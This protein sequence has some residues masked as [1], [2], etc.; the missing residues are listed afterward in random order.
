MNIIS[1]QGSQSM[2]PSNGPATH[3]MQPTA[4]NSPPIDHRGD[5]HIAGLSA[6]KHNRGNDSMSQLSPAK[7]AERRYSE[8][9]TVYKTL[10]M[11]I[12]KAT[13]KLFE[14]PQIRDACRGYI[15][16][17]CFLFRY[18]NRYRGR[19]DSSAQITDGTV[20]TMTVETTSTFFDSATQTGE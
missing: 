7:F 11:L 4:G 2:F 17:R 3:R 19:R 12:S 14:L 8:V 13:R 9:S 1:I 5:T 20:S 6:T 18:D 15:E 16:I 10:Q